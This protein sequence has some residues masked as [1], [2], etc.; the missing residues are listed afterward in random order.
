MLDPRLL[1]RK[2]Q[3][4]RAQASDFVFPFVLGFVVVFLVMVV[5]ALMKA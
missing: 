3:L 1:I 2:L 4:L 5:I